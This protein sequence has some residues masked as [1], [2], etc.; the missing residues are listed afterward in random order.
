MM[1]KPRRKKRIKSRFLVIYPK[2]GDY[3]EAYATNISESGMFVETPYPLSEGDD[4]EFFTNYDVL[5]KGVVRGSVRRLEIRGGRMRG[6]GISFAKGR[7][8]NYIR[9]LFLKQNTFNYK[10]L[11]LPRQGLSTPRMLYHRM[12]KS[13]GL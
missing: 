1:L 6:M 4:A 3:H 12:R 11:G 5:T 7:N 2:A 9:D 8:G 10:Y 13:L